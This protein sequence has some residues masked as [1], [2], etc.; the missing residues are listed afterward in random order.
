MGLE[1][2]VNVVVSA[3]APPLTE[4]GFGTPLILGT[5]P[6]A[7]TD[8][9]RYYT[10]LSG[11]VADYAVGTPEYRMAARCFAQTKRPRQIAIGKRTA[12][13]TQRFLLTPSQVLAN[14]RYAFSVGGVE[15]SY[16][17][18][19]NPTAAEL[20]AGITA[21]FGALSPAPATFAVTST[22]TNTTNTV[23]ASAAG[24]W[25]DFR[26]L[27]PSVLDAT[28][29]QVDAGVT[30]DLNAML[31][32]SGD[33]YGVL[34][35]FTSQAEVM[36]IAEWTEANRKL[37]FFATVDSA[38]YNSPYD[39]QGPDADVGGALF[40]RNYARTLGF[41]QGAT[42][43]FA[44]AA[45][46]A[47][48]FGA[49]PGS[50]TLNLQALVGPQPMALTG[51]QQ[52]NLKSRNMNMYLSLAGAPAFLDGSMFSGQFADIVRDTDWFV[53]RTQESLFRV[54]RS[55]DK[56]PYTDA[57]V[58]V[59]T[60]TVAAQGERAEVAGFL[61][62]GWA[63]NAQPVATVAEAD[64]AARRYPAITFTGTYAGA[65]HIVDPLTV[66]FTV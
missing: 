23:T 52:A 9:V 7:G 59:L 35:P 34:T 62:P 15:V 57:G 53:A 2:V 3:A 66:T 6:R 49:E 21:A 1:S 11:V 48:M 20:S 12:L 46:M 18:D 10:T 31:A 56:V 32:E 47:R 50:I 17:T 54:M 43:D 63:V 51:T 41:P 5:T 16:T 28:Q 61:S 8:L 40:S 55:N 30:N 58:V 64:R 29:T 45:L 36:A 60:A 22:D 14:T 26:V 4:A 25:L 65:I 44:D 24:A 39:E 38:T 19:A 27:T 13:P 37:F 42:S 33:W